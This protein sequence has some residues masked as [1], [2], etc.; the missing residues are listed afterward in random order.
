M[1]VRSLNQL[2]AGLRERRA[3][4]P[5][6]QIPFGDFD[7]F[8]QRIDVPPKIVVGQEIVDPSD[9]IVVVKRKYSVLKEILTRPLF[10][11]A[12]KVRVRFHWEGIQ[13]L[14]ANMES[15][16]CFVFPIPCNQPANW[17][18][19][20]SC[21]SSCPPGPRPLYVSIET[22]RQNLLLYAIWLLSK[23]VAGIA[24]CAM[25]VLPFL[26]FRYQTARNFVD[27]LAFGR[28]ASSDLTVAALVFF[29]IITFSKRFDEIFATLQKDETALE[30]VTRG[31]KL[32]S[33][34]IEVVKDRAAEAAQAYV[35]DLHRS[36][37]SRP[38]ST[39]GGSKR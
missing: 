29:L 20:I 16:N 3:A 39:R 2:L 18:L 7:D 9:P 24:L 25:A 37:R 14:G 30:S 11:I 13:V 33:G 23:L 17:Y 21:A 38:S 15:P 6:E 31:G 1:N 32:V 10:H 26:Y 22:L 35:H 8:I 36:S 27:Q 12:R 19:K 34:G 5:P 28:P 4:R